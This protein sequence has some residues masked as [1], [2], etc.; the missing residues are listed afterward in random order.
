MENSMGMHLVGKAAWLITALASIQVGALAVF[1]FN[2][3]SYVPES[4]QFIVMPIYCLY[5]I[6][7]I[8]SFVMLFM[9]CRCCE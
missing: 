9:H 5:L 6:A 8:Y 3:F 7:G 4:L 1:G 2:S